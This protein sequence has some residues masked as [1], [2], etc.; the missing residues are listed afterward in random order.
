MSGYVKANDLNM[1]YEIHGGGE[2]EPLVLLHGAFMT[3]DLNFGTMLPELA[4]GRRVI[5]VEL[6]G[7]GRTEDLDRP[8]RY[9]QMADDTAVLLRALE[10]RRADVLG[11]SMGGTTA[12]ELAIRHPDLVG[13]LVAISAPYDRDGWYP[14]VY[15]TLEQIT[16][17]VFTGSGLPEAYAAIAPNPAG[18]PTLVAKVKALDAGFVGR[19][20][21]EFRSIKA[22]T[23]IMVGDSDG[24][25]LDKGTEMFK[26]LGGGVFGDVAGLP[27]SQLAIIPGSTHV[28]VMQQTHLLVPMITAFLDAPAQ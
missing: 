7:H 6:Q 5:A 21:D 18:W 20:A 11:Y 28:G 12:I 9:E 15:A 4:R 19:T 24:V 10:I 16:P 14:E 22:P 13:K 25:P 27:K 8:L 17:D 26:L 2:G 3:I 23:L 1:Y